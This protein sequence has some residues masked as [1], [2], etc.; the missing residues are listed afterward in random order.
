MPPQIEF[1][2]FVPYEEIQQI[3]KNSQEFLTD[4]FC[5]LVNFSKK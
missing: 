3:V 4:P 5:A 2:R 1:E